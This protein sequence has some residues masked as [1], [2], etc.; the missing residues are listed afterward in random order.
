V[1]A[2]PFRVF[3]CTLPKSHASSIYYFHHFFSDPVL[4]YPPTHDVFK[5]VPSLHVFRLNFLFGSIFYCAFSV[6]TL[7]SV[8]ERVTSEWW[9]WIDEDKYTYLERDL[10][11]R[12]QCPS[13]QGLHLTPRGHWDRLLNSLMRAT[14]PNIFILHDVCVCVCEIT[15][16]LSTEFPPVSRY[17]KTVVT[18]SHKQ[19]SPQPRRSPQ[20]DTVRRSS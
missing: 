18:P 4:Y 16:L 6:T 2:K 20:N 12:S 7:H 10:N 17:S 13:D 11:P 15:M 5:Y 1:N 19:Q 9:W 8:D 14:C 3:Y